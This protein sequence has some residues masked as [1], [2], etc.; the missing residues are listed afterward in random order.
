MGYVQIV[1][2]AGKVDEDNPLPVQGSFSLEPSSTART[3]TF[4]RTNNAGTIAAGARSVLISNV[5]TASGSLLGSVLKA[6]E[7]VHF[8]P[9][10][11]VLTAIA[12][13]ATGTE[14]V[15]SDLR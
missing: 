11:G 8:T 9:S 10:D 2:G 3:P 14:F 15:I 5:G 13:N 12:Y 6:G 7:T 1:T 4:T